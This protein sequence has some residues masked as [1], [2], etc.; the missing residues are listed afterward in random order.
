MLAF[1]VLICPRSSSWKRGSEA[2]VLRE[3]SQPITAHSQ[4][5]RML[6]AERSPSELATGLFFELNLVLT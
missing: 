6:R 4:G 3:K 1:H 2:G 5:S